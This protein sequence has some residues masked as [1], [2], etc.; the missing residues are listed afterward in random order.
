MQVWGRDTRQAGE[1][2]RSSK[3]SKY[4]SEAESSTNV[5]NHEHSRRRGHQL[6]KKKSIFGIHSRQ[7]Y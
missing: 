2:H 7:I 4:L 1:V 3:D 6:K 5:V